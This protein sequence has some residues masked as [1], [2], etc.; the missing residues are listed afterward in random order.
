MILCKPPSIKTLNPKPR[1]HLQLENE[2]LITAA[3]TSIHK[4]HSLKNEENKKTNDRELNT[5]S[6]LKEIILKKLNK[7]EVN[8]PYTDIKFKKIEENTKT[9]VHNPADI[10]VQQPPTHVVINHPDLIIHPAPIIFH[11]PAAVIS[12]RSSK[13]RKFID[14]SKHSF[15]HIIDNKNKQNKESDEEVDSDI[16]KTKETNDKEQEDDNACDEDNIKFHSKPKTP[17]GRGQ[18]FS[19]FE[20]ENYDLPQKNVYTNSLYQPVVN[21]ELDK[22]EQYNLLSHHNRGSEIDQLKKNKQKITNIESNYK[23]LPTTKINTFTDLKDDYST[24]FDLKDNKYNKYQTDIAPQYAHSNKDTGELYSDVH[25]EDNDDAIELDPIKVKAAI[26]KYQTRLT[27]DYEDYSN[28]LYPYDEEEVVNPKQSYTKYSKEIDSSSSV[29]KSHHHHHSNHLFSKIQDDEQTE[30]KAALRKYEAS[31]YSYETNSEPIHI[32]TKRMKSLNKYSSNIDYPSYQQQKTSARNIYRDNE[33]IVIDPKQIKKIHKYHQNEQTAEK[34]S[35]RYP[36]YFHNHNQ[37]PQRYSSVT[38]EE[39]FLHLTAQKASNFDLE[40]DLQNSYK[41][42]PHS[43]ESNKLF[44]KHSYHT[45]PVKYRNNDNTNYQEPVHEDDE[46]ENE[47][48]EEEKEEEEEE[49]EGGEI[50]EEEEEGDIVEFTEN[51]RNEYVIDTKKLDNKKLKI[52]AIFSS[53]EDPESA[54]DKYQKQLHKP[55]RH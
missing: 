30:I 22:K 37:K 18:K 50:E 41:N 45:Q 14:E 54:M 17:S 12:A 52:E 10:H 39:N 38:E 11:R 47:E 31:P 3:I 42:Q 26:N 25:Q 2:K 33:A 28:K 8:K 5:K 49:K 43:S 7:D 35:M 6:A 53:D 48:G 36:E 21:K 23:L 19:S 9:I 13:G 40:E 27:S 20:K 34:K 1:R 32:K 15:E 16:I 24:N 44:N 51:D 55:Y 4:N 29:I 46:E